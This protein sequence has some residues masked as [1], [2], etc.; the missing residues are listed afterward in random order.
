ML[1]GNIWMACIM[2][3]KKRKE[4]SPGASSPLFAQGAPWS[5]GA[6]DRN[7][8]HKGSGQRGSDGAWLAARLLSS[9]V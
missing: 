5:L 7:P 3:R 6:T 4:M 2:A 9:A 8:N 1:F